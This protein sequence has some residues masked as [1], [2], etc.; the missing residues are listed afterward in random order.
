[1]LFINQE[2]CFTESGRDIA[3]LLSAIFVLTV[4]VLIVPRENRVDAVAVL[5]HA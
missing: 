1:M 4:A 3:V 2:N 5:N